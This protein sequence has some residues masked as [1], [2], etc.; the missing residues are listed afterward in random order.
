[1]AAAT[2]AASAESDSCA[3]GVGAAR[4]CVRSRQDGRSTTQAAVVVDHAEAADQSDARIRD[5]AAERRTGHLANGLGESEKAP[6]RAGLADG[7]LTAARVDRERAVVRKRVTADEL[8]SFALP[9][10]SQVF[11]LND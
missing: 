9:A 3:S 5:G 4:S 7:E 6:G 1:M 10:E 2:A 11:E 8:R